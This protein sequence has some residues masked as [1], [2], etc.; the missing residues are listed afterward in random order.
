MAVTESGRIPYIGNQEL[1]NL[2]R[3]FPEKRMQTYVGTLESDRD[4][5]QAVDIIKTGGIV[6]AQMWGVYGLWVDGANLEAVNRLHDEIKL[7]PPEKDRT[8]T[9][10][11]DSKDLEPFIDY[12]AIHPS[13]QPLFS[14]L[15]GLQKRVGALLHLRI[16]LVEGAVEKYNIPHTVYK[17]DGSRNLIQNLDPYG[18]EFMYN[19]IKQLNHSGTQFVAVT[20][21]NRSRVMPEITSLDEAQHFSNETKIPILLKDPLHRRRKIKGSFTIVHAGDL[22]AERE[23]SIS[24][25]LA[26]SLLG[27]S[28]EDEKIST[29]EMKKTIYNHSDFEDLLEGIS[30]P[31]HMREELL[32]YFKGQKSETVRWL[33]RAKRRM[34]K[35]LYNGHA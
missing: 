2:E 14:D 27:L 16:P 19:F 26:N 15:E 25:E 23:G 1:S 30:H 17:S 4:I 8:L 33:N 13:L 7:T 12:D 29:A 18:H 21:M 31:E 22:K 5:D 3:A 34:K 24:I 35:I 20:S 6:A 32:S 28:E 11:M 10:M 9:T